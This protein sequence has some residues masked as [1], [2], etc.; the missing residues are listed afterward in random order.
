MKA[1]VFHD[2]GGVGPVL[3]TFGLQGNRRAGVRL[4]CGGA[5][6]C[7][8]G[9]MG[10]TLGQNSLTGTSGS[11]SRWEGRKR[12]Q[13][14]SGLRPCRIVQEERG[15]QPARGQAAALTPAGAP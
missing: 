14:R 10:R 4:G 12:G 7:L 8:A 9:Q 2:V 13:G 11:E 3:V 6:E 5:R 1:A 15:S